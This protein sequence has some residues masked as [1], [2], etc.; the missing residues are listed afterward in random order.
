MVEAWP[1]LIRL[2]A[3]PVFVAVAIVDIRTRRIPRVVW[4]PVVGF[5][6]ILLAWEA[7]SYLGIGG[8]VW[9]V[10][11]IQVAISLGL[12]AP[13]GYVFWRIGAFGGADAKA[14]IAIAVLFPT[15]P[16]YVVG[17]VHLPIV[18]AP[19]GV[20]SFTVLT[21]AVLAG[22]VYPLGL[23]AVNAARGRFHPAMFVG[24]PVHWRSLE[25]RHGRML[26]SP[27][28]FTRAGLD[29]DALR[30]YLAW[31]DTDLETLRAS[32]D[33]FRDTLPTDPRHPGDGRVTDG[34]Q[35]ADPWG[36]RAFLN[37]ADGAYGTRPEELRGGLVLVV[38]RSHIW[39]SP[40]IPFLVLIAVGLL[41][42]LSYGDLFIRFLGPLLG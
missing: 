39:I 3:M 2:L 32:P 29:L 12:V 11:M 36:A 8:V 24:K 16:A 37:A 28:G 23:A 30:M 10:Y 1:D 33:R 4:P 17:D 19:L 5:G 9:R 31:R 14:I 25:R 42:G 15:Y 20:F 6:M 35:P 40:G 7:H 41:V 13:L 22:V 27:D 34:G 18:E 26:E 21:N 38:D